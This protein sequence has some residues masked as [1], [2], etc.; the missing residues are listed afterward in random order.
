MA[1]QTP[2]LS[3]LTGTD[4]DALQLIFTSLQEE[5]QR[6]EMALTKLEEQSNP[7]R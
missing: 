5:L 3:V 4:K 7:K 1:W 2:F 6:I